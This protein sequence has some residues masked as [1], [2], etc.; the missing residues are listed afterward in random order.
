MGEVNYLNIGC[1]AKFHEDWINIDMVPSDPLVKQADILK[2][3]PFA[4]DTFDAIYHSQ[5]LEHIPKEKAAEFIKECYRVLKPGGLIRIVVPDLENIIEEYRTQLLKNLEKTDEIAQANYEWIMLELYD[6]TVRN[7][8]GGGMA[9]YLKKPELVNEDYILGRIG[10][11]GT[12]IREQVKYLPRQTKVKTFIPFYLKAARKIKRYIKQL[13][14]KPGVLRMKL[15]QFILKKTEYSWL[16]LGKF[17]TGGEIH[18]W[19]Y[20]R[21]SLKNLLTDCGFKEVIL[22]TPFESSIPDWAEYELDVKAGKVYDPSSLFIEG[23][24][25]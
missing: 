12:T 7:Y 11:V 25:V 1:G 9:E 24:K 17:R 10:F 2:G 16:Q 3:L 6:Q 23:K 8:W 13:K 20:D 4:N 5:V 15:L 19:M 21:F 22:K 14:P 18:F